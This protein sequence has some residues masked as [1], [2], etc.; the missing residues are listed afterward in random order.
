MSEM[1]TNN[2]TVTDFEHAKVKVK[3]GWIQGYTEEAPNGTL[4]IYKGIPYA[5][6]PVGDL[7]LIHI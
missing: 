6:P 1:K 2:F 3:Q 7:S 4:K 5:E